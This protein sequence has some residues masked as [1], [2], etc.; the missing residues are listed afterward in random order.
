MEPTEGRQD[1]SPFALK[2]SQELSIMST[3]FEL[4]YIDT[5]PDCDVITSL[6]RLTHVLL[7]VQRL[8]HVL[9][10]FPSGPSPP[11]MDRSEKTYRLQ[12]PYQGQLPLHST[13]TRLPGT[14]V[15]S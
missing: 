6:Q 8:T 14:R 5:P 3:E 15:P 1:I 12:A 4:N 13:V 9:L 10:L 2:I 7:F 11:N